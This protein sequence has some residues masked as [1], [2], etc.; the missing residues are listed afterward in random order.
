MA[1]FIEFLPD[2]RWCFLVFSQHWTQ[3]FQG[4]PPHKSPRIANQ[5]AGKPLSKVL[6]PRCAFAFQQLVSQK[7]CVLFSAG[8]SKIMCL[9]MSGDNS[10]RSGRTHG[11]GTVMSFSAESKGLAHDA[12]WSL[13]SRDHIEIDE[14]VETSAEAAPCISRMG[15]HH[16]TSLISFINVTLEAQIEEEQRAQ[17]CATCSAA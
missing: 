2:L 9:A 14:I 12:S 15:R 13:M 4:E 16:S 5:E 11:S 10:S 8:R 3:T 6:S 17:A 1:S 7:K